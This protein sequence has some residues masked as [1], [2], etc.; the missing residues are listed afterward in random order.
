MEIEVLKTTRA[1]V[2]VAV[3]LVTEARRRKDGDKSFLTWHT[4]LDKVVT[5]YGLAWFVAVDLRCHADWMCVAR[6]Y[7]TSHLSARSW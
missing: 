1:Q 5:A 6:W 7:F 2:L 3:S 4:T